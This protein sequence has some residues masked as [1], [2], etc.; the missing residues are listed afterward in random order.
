[1]IFRRGHHG[2]EHTKEGA[3]PITISLIGK[4]DLASFTCQANS[5]SSKMSNI[6][7]YAI[8]WHLAIACAFLSQWAAVVVLFQQ[9][10]HS[11]SKVHVLALHYHRAC[12][13]THLQAS[14]LPAEACVSQ[15]PACGSHGQASLSTS[16]RIGRPSVASENDFLT[17]PVLGS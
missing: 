10:N 4:I 2:Y 14:V 11:S 1:M 8:V 17:C 16:G 13:R 6:Y 15:R 7:Y 12:I 9:H 5:T 3:K